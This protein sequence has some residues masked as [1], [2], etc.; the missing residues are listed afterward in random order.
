[1]TASVD[2]K[3]KIY[4]IRDL[5]TLPVIAKKIL[6][7]SSDDEQLAEKLCSIISK[8]QSLSVKVLTLANSAYYGHRAQIG[9]IKQAVVVIGTAMLRQ[10]SL[11]VLVSKGLG[12]GSSERELFWRHSLL[13]A[14]AATN[15]A[16]ACR[17]SNVEICFMAGLLHDVGKLVLDTN[18]PE[19]Y[20]RVAEIVEIERCSLIQAERQVF[21]TDHTQVGVWMAERWQLPPELVQ[22]IGLHHE[23]DLSALPHSQIVAVAHAASI[24]AE[25]VDMV[26]DSDPKVPQV[27]IPVEI[28]SILRLSQAQIMEIIEGLQDRKSE[29]QSLF[30]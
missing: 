7:L 13:S 21:D 14:N 9:T 23:L 11:G 19:E 24:C 15:I 22:S 17:I 26:D 1:M 6:G 12:Q 25:V 29:I 18:V 8:D 2:Y 3:R 10:F 16:K 20:K 4:A 30:E 5:P 28:Q 27:F